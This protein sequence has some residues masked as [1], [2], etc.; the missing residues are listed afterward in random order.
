[1]DCNHS[2]QLSIV[3]LWEVF[4]NERSALLKGGC[5]LIGKKIEAAYTT[6]YFRIS[7]LRNY[8]YNICRGFT[9]FTVYICIL[10]IQK[11]FVT[12]GRTVELTL[13]TIVYRGKERQTVNA[14]TLA[15]PLQPHRGPPY[16]TKAAHGASQARLEGIGGSQ[17]A[18]AAK[19]S[20]RFLPLPYYSF[21]KKSNTKISCTYAFC[22]KATCHG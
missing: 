17:L 19:A 9:I 21:R 2:S 1:M 8:I 7:S 16:T 11:L 20:I 4:S 15:F 13:F 5:M 3:E 10:Q 12:F 22:N 14:L 6:S 18:S